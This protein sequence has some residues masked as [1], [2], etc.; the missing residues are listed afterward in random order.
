[1]LHKNDGKWALGCGSTGG[2][3]RCLVTQLP[4]LK[5]PGEADYNEDKSL[6]KCFSSLNLDANGGLQLIRDHRYKWTFL[7]TFVLSQRS[8]L[9]SNSFVSDIQYTQRSQLVF[10]FGAWG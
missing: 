8:D 1:M 3:C 6:K 5:G 9:W 7:N 2:G 4:W 10:D